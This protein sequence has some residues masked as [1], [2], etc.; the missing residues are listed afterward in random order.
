MRLASPRSPKGRCS[1]IASA[2]MRGSDRPGRGLQEW[3]CGYQPFPERS[4]P[5]AMPV[6]AI[7]ALSFE[8]AEAAVPTA[9][10]GSDWVKHVMG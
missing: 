4:E 10:M 3:D 7:P 1:K 6:T 8:T 9:G 5:S 2:A